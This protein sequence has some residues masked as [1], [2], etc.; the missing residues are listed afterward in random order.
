[1]SWLVGAQVENRPADGT[2][3]GKSPQFR[4]QVVVDFGLYRLGAGDVHVVLMGLQVGDLLG[5]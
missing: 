1:M 2:L 5:G 3:F 4:H